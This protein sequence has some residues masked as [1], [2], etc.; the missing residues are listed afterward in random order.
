MQIT[1]R[2]IEAVHGRVIR[3]MVDKAIVMPFVQRCD[4]ARDASGNAQA[5]RRLHPKPFLHILLPVRC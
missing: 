3:G 1:S 5:K 2:P 4:E